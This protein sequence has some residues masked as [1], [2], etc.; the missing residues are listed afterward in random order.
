MD[1]RPKLS[2]IQIDKYDEEYLGTALEIY[3]WLE[4][5]KV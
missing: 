5:K 2:G 1:I 3:N 4:S